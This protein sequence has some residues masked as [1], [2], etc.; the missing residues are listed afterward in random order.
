[1][2]SV[3]L[4]GVAL[5]AAVAGSAMAADMNTGMGPA[6][7]LTKAPPP[8]GPGEGGYAYGPSKHTAE[9]GP[10]PGVDIT[11]VFNMNGEIAGGTIGCNYQTSNFVLGIED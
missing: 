3:F 10:A 4:A 7:A 9:S 6:P 1:M 8:M 5:L 2:K 11:P